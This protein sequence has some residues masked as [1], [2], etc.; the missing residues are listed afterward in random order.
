M[1]E[2]NLKIDEK[3]SKINKEMVQIIL[4]ILLANYTFFVRFYSNYFTG[5]RST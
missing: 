4:Y 1:N 3:N 2:L 5:L